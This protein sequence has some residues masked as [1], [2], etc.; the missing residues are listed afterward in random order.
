MRRQLT[1]AIGVVAL[2]VLGLVY[3]FASGNEPLL[4]LDLQGGVSVVLEPEPNPDGSDVDNE[5][6]DQAIEVIRNRVDGLG[7]REPEITRQGQ[8][9]LVQIPGVDDQAR[10]LELV[11]QTAEL[12]FRPVLVEAPLGTD[13]TTLAGLCPIGEDQELPPEYASGTPTPDAGADECLIAEQT[14]STDGIDIDTLLLLGPAPELIE[15]GDTGARLTGLAVEDANARLQ[16]G[17][18]VALEL[19]S[20]SPGIDDFNSLASLCFSRSTVCPSGRVAI[21]IDGGVESAPTI[22][23]PTFERTNI[24]ISG[25]FSEGEAKDLALVLRYGSLPVELTPQESRSVSATLGKDALDAGV[26]A[27]L[28]GFALV[29]LY[30]I[31]YYRLLGLV[32]IASL[33]VSGAMLWTII[34]WLGDSQGLALTLAGVTGLIVSVGVSVDSNV[35]FFEH[36][37]EDVRHGRT[38]RSAVTRS[39]P[40]AFSTIVK[41]DVASLIAAVVLYVLTVGQVKGFALFLGLATVLDIVATYFFMGPVVRLMAEREAMAD[42]PG[43]YGL[44]P[45]EEAR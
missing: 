3:T 10:A 27:G 40:I 2:S 45:A 1:L 20:G 39:F 17:W 28:I 42:H 4:G 22:Q 30:L 24:S 25:N 32:A 11:G 12:R 33:A 35:V 31:A 29:S 41:A 44:V 13:L 14:V 7:V 34:A 37:K 6:I 18:N 5:V 19:R 8:T 36:L 23:S 43:R 26:T 9:V 15:G 21:E 38:M 16:A